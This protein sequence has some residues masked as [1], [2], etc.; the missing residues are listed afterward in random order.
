MFHRFQPS[1]DALDPR[2]HLFILMQQERALARQSPV[3]LAQ[4]TILL[5]QLLNRG[6][7]IFD[8]FAEP[9]EFQVERCFCCFAH[10]EDYRASLFA[11]SM[12]SVRRR[13]GHNTGQMHMTS[14]AEIQRVLIEERSMSEPAEAH[15]TLAGSLCTAVTYRFEDWLLEILPDGRA[16]AAAAAEAL[17]EV[18]ARTA[19]ALVGIDVAFDLLLP[20]DEQPIDTRT[21]ALA[22]W[23]QGFLYGLG[24][25]VIQD[26]SRLPGGAG[27]VVRDLS[28]ITRVGIDADDSLESNESAFTELVEFVRVGVQLVF[29]ELEPV[30]GH[31]S[32]VDGPLH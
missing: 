27:E 32:L 7:Q 28:E 9:G 15:G 26:A 13:F 24:S 17:R 20:E 14:Y 1:D 31:S 18:Y 30:R 4:G 29:A 23:C 11:R 10:G 16:Q 25:R 22:Q 19:Q 5:L 8:A 12:R 2:A 6:G 3:P 21:A